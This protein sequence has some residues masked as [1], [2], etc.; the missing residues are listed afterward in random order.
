MALAIAFDDVKNNQITVEGNADKGT[1]GTVL[2]TD[3]FNTPDSAEAPHAGLY[4]FAPGRVSHPH[5]HR[6]DQFQVV[7]AGKGKMGRHDLTTYSVHFSRAY[8]PYGPFICDA[9]TGLT[10]F[11]MHAHT[12]PDWRSQHF[13]QAQD[14][15]RQVTDRQ[16]WQVTFP[17]A[18]PVL[19]SDATS[20][21]AMLQDVP[22]SKDEHG[23]ATYTLSMKPNTRASAPDPSHGDGQYLV[24]VK[25]SLLHNNSE[26]KA[27]A[28]VYVESKEAPYR[29]HAGAGGL[30]AIVVNYPRPLAWKTDTGT[31][32]Q[33]T[34]GFRKWQCMLCAFVYDE[35][36]GLP[37]EGI[38][39]GT[40]WQDVP[41]SW[42]CPDCSASKADFEMTELAK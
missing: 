9:G 33:A 16:P 41:E 37:E 11:V 28:L 25:G 15:L 38:P 31:H 4:Q 12:K 22:G 10:C 8:T 21:D 26:H 40:R 1:F 35:A 2:A 23:L 27:L 3:F 32:A 5:F 24:V 36:A 19:Q 6:V 17:V 18:F 42:S 13:P 14:Q 39:P 30:E 34:A 20:A 7:V 29:V